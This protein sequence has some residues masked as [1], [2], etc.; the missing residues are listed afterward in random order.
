MLSDQPVAKKSGL[1]GRR[2]AWM[3]EVVPGNFPPGA[4]NIF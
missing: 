4:K 2:R 1:N 3:I